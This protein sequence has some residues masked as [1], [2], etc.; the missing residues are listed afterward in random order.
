LDPAF[1]VNREEDET[2]PIR[3]HS[4]QITARFLSPDGS[5]VMKSL[6]VRFDP[7]LGTSSRIAEGVILSKADE[8]ALA[9]LQTPDSGCPFCPDRISRVTPNVLEPIH[10]G[11]RLERG[12]FGVVS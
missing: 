5:E 3:F 2:R 8:G 7:L 12:E 1:A 10:H 6:E 11:G 4:E 9:L